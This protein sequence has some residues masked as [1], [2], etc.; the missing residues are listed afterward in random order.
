MDPR[1]GPVS[2]EPLLALVGPT[3]S[4]KT[5]LGLSVA[6]ELDAEIVSADSMLVYRGMD[7]GTAKPTRA[8][9]ARVPHHLVD[10]IAPSEPFS[11]ARYQVLAREAIAGIR[12]DRRRPLLVGGSGLYVRAAV[13][14]LVFPGTDPEIRSELEREA[15]ALGPARLYARLADLDPVAAAKIEPGNLRR[16]VR[17]LE[18]P[19]LTGRT[20]GSFAEAWERYDPAGVRVAGLS[21]P[22]EV[23]GERIRSRVEAMVQRGWLE[24]VRRLVG[25]GFGGWLT[26]SQAIG[27]AELARHLEG[28]LALEEALELTMRRTKALARRQMSWFRRDPR[29]RWFEVGEDP[30]TLAVDVRTYLAGEMA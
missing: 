1:T 3:A 18:V 24:E 15:A 11:V 14:P 30:A 25:Q 9:Q 6:L 12:A 26:A 29:I 13:D 10:L 7:I 4:G 19:A 8:D 23:L 21:V 16:I 28:T 5:A 27:Y 17:A 20:F 22:A 2:T